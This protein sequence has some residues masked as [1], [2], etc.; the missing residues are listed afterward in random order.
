[1]DTKAKAKFN[2]RMGGKRQKLSK[3]GLIRKVGN[4]MYFDDGGSVPS[5][6]LGTP[7]NPSAGNTPNTNNLTTSAN[8]SGNT[9]ANSPGSPGNPLGLS[10]QANSILN[11][12]TGLVSGVA[13]PLVNG[14]TG[15]LNN[16]FTAQ[17]V[18][19]QQGTNVSQLNNAY[20]GAQG[21]LG[22][23]GTLQGQVAGQVPTAVANQN[24]LAAQELALT[25]GQGPNPAQAQLAQNTS[26]N[27]ANQAALM[28]G[29]RGAS[30]NAGLIAR[31]AAQQ[32]AA[33]QQASVGQAATLQAQQ[34]LAAQQNL[35]ALS[36]QQVNQTGQATSNL[37]TAAQGEQGILQNANTA[38]NNTAV[39]QQ[40][41]LNSVN[42]GVAAGNQAMAGNIFGGITSGAS[43][44]LGS[45]AQGGEVHA[46]DD[47][48]IVNEGTITPGSDSS[49]SSP[50]IAPPPAPTTL[51]SFSSSSGKSGGS[52][53][54]I[55]ALAAAFA[56]GGNITPGPHK[57]HVAN[58]L[59]ASGGKVPAMV[60]PGERYLNPEEVR[61]VIHEGAN[62]MKIGKKF[63]GKPKVKGD[64]LKN[65]VIPE[66]LEEGGVV[67]PRHVE[68][69]KDAEKSE[70]FVRRAVHMRKPKKDA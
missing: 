57:S 15:F 28:A 63:L 41:G 7:A 33:T 36:N 56:K 16:N 48:G 51:P 50:T 39:S 34:Q 47:G 46:Y 11:P 19:I 43:S 70:L 6:T 9:L 66:D 42:A 68:L 37:N 31:Q 54:G 27:V 8:N 10:P 40:S 67:I 55:A 65:D 14:V 45:L 26:T 3:G 20:T 29:Q 21:A 64:S 60:S 44:I 59:M 38:A 49:G 32:G 24:T 30:Q 58:F 62:P 22:A 18:P 17:G 1:M 25:Q 4:R 23:Q 13:Q 5:T 12:G 61:Q 35:A 69:K 52:G 2:H 53:G